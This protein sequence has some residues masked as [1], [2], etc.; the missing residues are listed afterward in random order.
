MRIVLCG[1]RT[2]CWVLEI[3]FKD[4]NPIDS[5]WAVVFILTR[6]SSELEFLFCACSGLEVRE[7]CT[8][9]NVCEGLA[10]VI[11]YVGLDPMISLIKACAINAC[12]VYY[13]E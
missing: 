3:S 7:Y 1:F 8:P 13:A 5:A 6:Y 10:R 4:W 9:Y 11:V 12:D 2:W